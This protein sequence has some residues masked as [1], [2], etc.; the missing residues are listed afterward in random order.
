MLQE[1]FQRLDRLEGLIV[2]NQAA[3][4]PSFRAQLDTPMATPSL[5]MNHRATFSKYIVVIR[6]SI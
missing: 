6:V 4:L 5:Q 1:I 3:P 2:T